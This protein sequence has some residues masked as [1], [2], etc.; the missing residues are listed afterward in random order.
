MFQHPISFAL[1]VLGIAVSFPADADAFS[2]AADG[3]GS[4]KTFWYTARVKV[5][6]A[7]GTV[8]TKPVVGV[9]IKAGD[10]R[11][12]VDKARADAIRKVI[13]ENVG[14]VDENTV[15]VKIHESSGGRPEPGVAARV[16]VSLTCDYEKIL[17]HVQDVSIGGAIE[18]SGHDVKADTFNVGLVVTADGLETVR[19]GQIRTFG[20][21]DPSGWFLSFPVWQ[22]W[23]L[24]DGNTKDI[25]I[26]IFQNAFDPELKQV[27]P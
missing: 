16:Q 3:K 11:E 9:G 19:Q 22:D 23:I 12:A 21:S 18:I 4:E 14:R 20:R 17:R 27:L 24:P 1:V 25:Q 26:K 15:E 10:E 7:D 13:S 6:V 5:A 8:L 2:A